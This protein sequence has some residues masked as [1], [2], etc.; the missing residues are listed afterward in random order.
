MEI[1]RDIAMIETYEFFVESKDDPFDVLDKARAVATE[2]YGPEFADELCQHLALRLFEGDD[3]LIDAEDEGGAEIR[4][5][6][7]EAHEIIAA[8][9]GGDYADEAIRQL[10]TRLMA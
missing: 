4:P 10:A 2:Q 8:S 3:P 1:D 7:A 6:F 5:E 9:Q